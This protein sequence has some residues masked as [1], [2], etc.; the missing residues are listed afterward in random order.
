MEAVPCKGGFLHGSGRHRDAAAAV[1]DEEE[2][3]GEEQEGGGGGGE[4]K[5]GGG[6]AATGSR[7]AGR[8]LLGE[9]KHVL[10]LPLGHRKLVQVT[11]KARL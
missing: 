9:C 11:S 2:K 7:P 3:E 5:E 1:A 10:P 8:L 6:Q 4:Q